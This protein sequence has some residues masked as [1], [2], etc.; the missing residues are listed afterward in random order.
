VM[1]AGECNL[2]RLLILVGA[3]RRCWSCGTLVLYVDENA[4]TDSAFVCGEC[5]DRRQRFGQEC[6]RAAHGRFS[7]IKRWFTFMPAN[8]NA[9]PL[10]MA[11]R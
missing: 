9:R 3:W 11:A 5:Q 8:D 1:D 6:L 10:V 4:R 2:L 7:G